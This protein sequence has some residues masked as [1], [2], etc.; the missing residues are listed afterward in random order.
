MT[1]TADL[2]TF[3]AV[4]TVVIA[5][6]GQDTALTVKNTLA[7]G[8]KGGILTALGVISGQL[9]WALGTSLGLTG[10][11]LASEQAFLALK[12][13]GAAYLVYLGTTALANAARGDHPAA[14]QAQPPLAVTTAYRQG[15]LSN[16]GNPKVAVFFTSLLPQFVPPSERSFDALL[17]LG[18]LFAAITLVWLA[19]YAFVVA[20]A[21]NIVDRPR[22]RRIIDLV[23]GFVLVGL[24][25]RLALEGT[26]G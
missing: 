21:A 2:A 8:R 18:V 4:A 11:L 1:I 13:A 25:A 20:K 24:G 6:P 10:L 15:L 23:T 14:A 12:L 17:L 22:A 16:L 26:S 9:T 3:F 5:T 19:G 7:G